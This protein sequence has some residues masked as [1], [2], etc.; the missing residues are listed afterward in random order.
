MTESNLLQW[1]YHSKAMIRDLIAHATIG[2]LKRGHK[3]GVDQKVIIFLMVLKFNLSCADIAITFDVTRSTV[4][5]ARTEVENSLK[6]CV[7]NI[8]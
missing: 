4:Q 3:L 6:A 1:T 5:R 7:Q 8:Y 2:G